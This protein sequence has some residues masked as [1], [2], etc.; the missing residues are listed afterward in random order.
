MSEETRVSEK[1]H[2][3]RLF[4]FLF[5]QE[6]HKDWT[7][8]LYNAVNHSNYTDPEEIEFN[9]IKE[10]LYLGMHNDVS[11]LIA[12]EVNLYEHQ[13][14]YNPNMPLRQMQ[15]LAGMYEAYL[16]KHKLNKYGRT[17]IILPVPHL[18]VF[19]NGLQEMDNEVTLRLSDAFPSERREESDVEVTVHMLNINLEHNREFLAKCRPLFEYSW[20]VETTRQFK[21]KYDDDAFDEAIKIMPLDFMIRERILA[22]REEVKTMLLTEYDE[23]ESRELFRLEGQ[24]E[25]EKIGEEKATFNYIQNLMRKKNYS[26]QEAM[27][28]LDLSPEDQEK[29]LQLLKN[30]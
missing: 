23:K 6:E 13:S 16:K 18:I 25:G 19:Y 4:L 20:L 14:T 11:F 30:Q 17:Q 22:H 21:S 24:R 12:D 26:A 9:T 27:D 1:K 7:L 8:S 2:K 15:Y 28:A 10:A 3:D 29:Y 5:G